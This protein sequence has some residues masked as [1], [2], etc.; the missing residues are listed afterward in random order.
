[1]TEDEKAIGVIVGRFQV[2]KLTEGH[3]EIFEHVLSKKH[4]MNLVFLGIPPADVHATKRN[5]IPFK[6]RKAMIERKYPNGEFDIMYI[7]DVGNV[8]VTEE[9]Q[10]AGIFV[11]DKSDI[12]WSKKLDEEILKATDGNTNVF[13]Y[14]SR[15]SFINHYRGR[16]QT[17][18]Y[19]QKQFSSGT[20]SRGDIGQLIGTTEDFARGCIYTTQKSWCYFFYTVDCAIF[21]DNKFT[22]MY[23]GKKKGERKFRFPGGFLDKKDV[24]VEEAAVREAREETG[25]A[26]SVIAPLG[27]MRIE[28]GRY[29]NEE[30]SIMTNLFLMVAP[31]QKPCVGDDLDYLEMVEFDKL[32]YEDFLPCHQPLFGKLKAVIEKIKNNEHIY[33]YNF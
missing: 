11:A 10:K 13:L 6:T 8:E 24:N 2:S 23:L 28:D 7:Q 21:S 29:S 5:P 20:V 22:H 31:N 19:V 33:N 4:Q 25:L 3:C 26:C 9:E 27:T 32:Q 15:D 12:L 18:E 16:F 30:E 14:G 1:M 17:R